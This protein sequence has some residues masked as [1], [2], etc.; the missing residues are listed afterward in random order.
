[1]R[2]MSCASALTTAAVEHWKAAHARQNENPARARL[3]VELR[4]A[5]D[6]IGAVGEIEIVDAERERGSHDAIGIGT[7]GLERPARVDD[8][9]GREL[10]QLPLDVA[11]AVEHRGHGRCRGSKA[12]AKS[13]R[14]R[15]R[16]T[17]DDQRQTRLIGQELRQ[18]PAEGAVASEDQDLECRHPGNRFSPHIPGT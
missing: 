12:C 5:S 7:V 14:F 3:R 2:V 15:E 17:R 10:A 18:P 1:M 9:V 11:V 4:D 16:T 8:H 13:L 6:E